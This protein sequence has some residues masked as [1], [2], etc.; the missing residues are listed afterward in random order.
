MKPAW[1]KISEQQGLWRANT[2][3]KCGSY[4]SGGEGDDWGGDGW[5]ASL[6]R[7]TWVWASSGSWWWTGRPGVLQSMGLQRVEHD[8]VTELTDRLT[9]QLVSSTNEISWHL[10]NPSLNYAVHIY[11]NF[12][13]TNMY[14]STTQS[15][16]GWITGY[17][18]TDRESWL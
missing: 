15:V 6:T 7:W 12:F 3:S 10:S 8:R 13:S 2:P 1:Y 14:Y 18:T 5:M 17:G 9:K 4:Q 16:V 11:V